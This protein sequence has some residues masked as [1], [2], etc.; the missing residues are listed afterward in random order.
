[1]PGYVLIEQ[2]Y[3]K[4]FHEHGLQPH[5]NRIGFLDFLREIEVG[6]MDL[7]PY[8]A[9]LVYGLEQALYA[10]SESNRGEI[11]QVFGKK[12]RNAA[13][14]LEAKKIQVQ[15]V[16][17]GTLQNAATVY[18]DYRRERLPIDFIFGRPQKTLLGNEVCCFNASF[19]L[20][21]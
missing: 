19:N 13:Q 11:A 14:S 12:L 3:L 15:I 10:A 4:P 1:M 9:Y 20:T 6:G 21:S 7:N 8:S 2:K 17:T 5:A 16:F 18:L